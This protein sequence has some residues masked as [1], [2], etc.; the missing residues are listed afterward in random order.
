MTMIVVNVHEAKAR[1]SEYL[2]AVECGE[3]VVIGRRNRPVAELRPSS[4]VRREPRP[5][6]LDRG[7][8]AVPLSFFDPLPDDLRT[9]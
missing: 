8:L 4:A 1:L 5:I 6:G 3:H 7:R 2:D 9:F